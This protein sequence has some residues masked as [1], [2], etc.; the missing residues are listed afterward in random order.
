MIL[1]FHWVKGYRKDPNK[2]IL[3]QI[4]FYINRIMYINSIPKKNYK[5]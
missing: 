4:M 1:K 3:T 5:I 2:K